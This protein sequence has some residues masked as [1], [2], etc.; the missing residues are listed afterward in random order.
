MFNRLTVYVKEDPFANRRWYIV[1]GNA[2]ICSHLTANNS[3][4]VQL[5]AVICIGYGGREGWFTIVAQYHTSKSYSKGIRDNCFSCSNANCKVSKY[6]YS[7]EG[8][9]PESYPN[10]RHTVHKFFSRAL[11]PERPRDRKEIK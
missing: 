2:Q 5:T 6:V 9:A 11:G 3:R 10:K 4:E 8:R 7:Q 1:G